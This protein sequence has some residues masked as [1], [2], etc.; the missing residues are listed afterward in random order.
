LESNYP[1]LFLD[2]EITSPHDQE[3][4][5]RCLDAVLAE[6]AIAVEDIVGLGENGTG[7]NRDLYVVHRQAITLARQRGIFN[8]RIELE[9]LCSTAS[10]AR[11]RAT[12]EGFKGTD[13][14]ITG[15]DARGEVVLRISWGLGGPDWV[16]PLVLGQRQQLFDLIGRAM[17]DA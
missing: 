2:A 9:R 1:N 14:T 5:V 8:K 12:Q 17:D 3:K 10:I 4:Y 13:L 11:L 15:H 6:E 7:S 16:E